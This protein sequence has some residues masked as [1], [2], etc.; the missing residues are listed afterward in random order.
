[1]D[2]VLL[3]VVHF[4]VAEVWLEVVVYN[5]V[6]SFYPIL[7]SAGWEGKVV[8]RRGKNHHFQT[9]KKLCIKAMGLLLGGRLFWE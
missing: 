9:I 2:T 1:M 7:S 3:E 6:M 5:L 4:T 8:N